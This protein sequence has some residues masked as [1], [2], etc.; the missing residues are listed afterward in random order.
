MQH[1]AYAPDN[2]GRQIE[3]AITLV[4]L[5]TEDGSRLPYAQLQDLLDMEVEPPVLDDALFRLVRRSVVSIEGQA[6]QLIDSQGRRQQLDLLAAVVLHVLVTA[7]QALMAAE[8]AE[9]CERDYSKPKQREE[10]ELALGWLAEDELARRE[11]DG[12]HPTRPAV[13]AAELSF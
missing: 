4:L 1:P 10:V 12:W 5:R 13:R 8:V 9:E 11:D 6:I 7:R 2:H 3:Q